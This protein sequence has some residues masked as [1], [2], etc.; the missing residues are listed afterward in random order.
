MNANERES[1]EPGEALY[2]AG[3]FNADANDLADE[4]DDVAGVVFTVRVG[5]ALHLVLVDDPFEG[6]A[7][8]V[9]ERLPNEEDAEGDSEKLCEHNKIIGPTRIQQRVVFWHFVPGA[10]VQ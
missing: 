5:V 9:V 10:I 4:A 3:G 7:E 2:N 6:G 1:K 8:A